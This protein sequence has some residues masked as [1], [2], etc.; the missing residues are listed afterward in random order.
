VSKSVTYLPTSEGEAKP[1][2]APFDG[3][4]EIA[5]DTLVL[6]ANASAHQFATKSLASMQL[7]IAKKRPLSKLVTVITSGSLNLHDLMR[8]KGT[9]ATQRYIINEVLRIYAAQ[10]QDVADKHLEIIVRQMFSRVQVEDPG[11]S[12]VRYG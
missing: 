9:E 1:L 7:V 5:E 11:D 3:V 4:V 2:V 12:D 6:A 10:G 8:L